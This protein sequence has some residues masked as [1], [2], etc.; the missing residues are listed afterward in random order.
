MGKISLVSSSFQC[1]PSSPFHRNFI[2]HN[3]WLC[4]ENGILAFWLT[5]LGLWPVSLTTR[6]QW[7][8]L[9][10]DIAMQKLTVGLNWKSGAC[11]LGTMGIHVFYSALNEHCTSSKSL[12][13][14]GRAPSGGGILSWG[15]Q[16]VHCSGKSRVF[17]IWVFLFAYIY[18]L[19]ISN[20]WMFA[21]VFV[22]R[23]PLSVSKGRGSAAG[24][25]GVAA[26]IA[27]LSLHFY[28]NTT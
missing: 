15:P 18:K 25:E 11:R 2:H 28:Q 8:L 19:I 5:Y 26:S 10:R 17:W 21:M 13:I 6:L 23:K 1:V 14:L 12:F 9:I 3:V 4:V 27:C 16:G 20:D 7:S 24:V 22:K